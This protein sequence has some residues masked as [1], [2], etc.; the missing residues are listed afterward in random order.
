M[1]F[2]RTRLLLLLPEP[3]FPAGW[4]PLRNFNVHE[5]RG[6]NPLSILPHIVPRLSQSYI[7]RRFGGRVEKALQFAVRRV[8]V[9]HLVALR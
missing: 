1:L 8:G 4:Q 5:S 7:Q 6:L 9:H 2:H 3:R